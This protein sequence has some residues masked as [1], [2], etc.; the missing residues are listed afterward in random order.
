M[1]QKVCLDT[2]T[3]I[4]IIKDNPKGKEILNL[5]EDFEIF[6]SVVSVFELYLRDSGLDKIDFFLERVNILEFDYLSARESSNLFRELKNK[7]LAIDFRD[8]FIAATCLVNNCNLL[9]LNK[10]HFERISRLKLQGSSNEI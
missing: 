10:K 8:V 3:C 5:I 4:E 7:G 9:T 2:D 6:V 1:E